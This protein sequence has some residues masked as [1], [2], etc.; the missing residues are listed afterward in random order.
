MDQNE[1]YSEVAIMES[2]PA[3]ESAAGRISL[4]AGVAALQMGPQ[5]SPKTGQ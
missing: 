1:R 2:E 5:R 4:P 3:V